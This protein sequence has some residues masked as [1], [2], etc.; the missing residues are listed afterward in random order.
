M[1]RNE[2]IIIDTIIKLVTIMF[3]EHGSIRVTYEIIKD[4]AGKKLGDGFIKRNKIP[5]KT[6]L[7]AIQQNLEKE[8]ATCIKKHG[9][10]GQATIVCVKGKP[11]ELND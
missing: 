3:Q 7:Q 8:G 4:I 2:E 5:K 10:H 1:S 11:L 6:I 9:H